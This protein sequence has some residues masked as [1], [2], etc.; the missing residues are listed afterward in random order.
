MTQSLFKVF[1]SETY[2]LVRSSSSTKELEKASCIDHF[3]SLEN[4]SN[5]DE[6]T[7]SLEKLLTD[8][9]YICNVLPKTPHTNNILG[10]G[11]LEYCK[12]NYNGILRNR[13]YSII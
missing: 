6:N 4:S 2:G 10:K 3:C 5:Q 7:W 11:N 1:G 9:D 13:S 8:C 12:G